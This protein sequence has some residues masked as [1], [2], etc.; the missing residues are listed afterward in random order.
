[1]K[2]SFDHISDPNKANSARLD[3]RSLKHTTSSSHPRIVEVNGDEGSNGA[4]D[5]SSPQ[6]IIEEPD[7]PPAIRRTQSETNANDYYPQQRP[8][9]F[10]FNAAHMQPPVFA[11]SAGSA[12]A[13]F[14]RP[15]GFPRPPMHH[16]HSHPQMHQQHFVHPQFIHQ[17]HPMMSAQGILIEMMDE[18]DVY[19]H[20]PNGHMNGADDSLYMVTA[21]GQRI[22][23]TEEQVRLLLHNV[24]QQQTYQENLQQQQQFHQQQQQ[25]QQQQQQQQQQYFQQ[26]AQH[27]QQRPFPE[28]Q[29]F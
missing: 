17:Y 9:P 1:M 12:A 20:T 15:Q 5:P 28:Q 14:N 19:N 23:M 6:P 10:F 8:S 7:D 21:N 26:Q 29:R 22:I 2:F 27:R 24:H 13:Y 3:Q 4:S 25:F 18:P 11:M 16:P